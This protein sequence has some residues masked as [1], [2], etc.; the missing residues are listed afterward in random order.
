MKPVAIFGINVLASFASSIVAALLFALPWLQA[1]NVHI[2]LL[3]LV[4]PHM[5]LRFIGL[6]FLVPGVVSTSLSKSWAAPAAYG[7][8]IAGVLAIVATGALACNASWAIAAIWIFNIWGMLDLLYGFYNG[9]RANM[10]LNPGALGAGYYLVTAIVPPLLVSHAL[11]FVF[12]L[13]NGG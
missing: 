5:F 2:A 8:L 4:A 3:W 11:I 13:R 1:Q 9:I 7:D 6:S 12:L 10:A